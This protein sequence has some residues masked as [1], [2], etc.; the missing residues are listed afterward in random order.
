[1]NVY[2]VSSYRQRLTFLREIGPDAV[3]HF[4]HGRMVMG[5]AD[6]AVEWLKE[7][8]IPIFSPLSMLETQEEWESD[9][10]GMFGDSC[11][12]VSSY[13]NWTARSTPTC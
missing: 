7:R 6:A 3:I 5:Q 11:P 1:M 2:P 13:P 8:N 4:A 9:P 12:R 10:M